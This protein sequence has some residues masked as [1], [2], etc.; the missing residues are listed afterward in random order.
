MALRLGRAKAA[1]VALAVVGIFAIA[2]PASAASFVLTNGSLTVTIGD[3]GQISALTFG[4]SDFYNPGTPV[5]DFGFQVGTN[6]ATYAAN[7][8]SFGDSMPGSSSDPT[9][10]GTYAGAGGTDNVT[11]TYSL[12]PG[13]N[14]LKVTTTVTNNTAGS[15]TIRA[16]DTFDPDQ[17]IDQGGGFATTNDIY[18]LGGGSVLR[19]IGPGSGLTVIMGFADAGSF[20][21]GSWDF[22]LGVISGDDVN[23]CFDAPSDPG[24]GTAD[25]GMCIGSEL[26]IAPG[27]TATWTYYQAY[28]TSVGAAEAAF[29]AAV[30]EPTTLVLFGLGLAGAARRLRR[31]RS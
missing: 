13:Q 26:V 30:P 18:S 20:A 29:L 10:T 2:T 23:R 31:R 11:K 27:A 9:W 15:L 22:I 24:G 12:V 17:D 28:G 19:A 6:T 3:D 16:F 7:S 1:A 14:V 25:I 8:H 5:A 21:D 4:G